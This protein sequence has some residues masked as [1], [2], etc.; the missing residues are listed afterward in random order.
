MKI[1]WTEETRNKN[2]NPSLWSLFRFRLW[3]TW[4]SREL[5]LNT[6]VFILFVK[7]LIISNL[8]FWNYFP[9]ENP[10]KI[11]LAA[12]IFSWLRSFLVKSIVDLISRTVSISWFT[13]NP[14]ASLVNYRNTV[15]Y[16]T[17][18]H[19]HARIKRGVRGVP[20]SPT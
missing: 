10:Q 17:L 18:E 9:R 2:T 15:C 19:V 20:T 13:P 16:V 1:I 7:D 8:K 5:S 11:S 14:C 4:L 12:V 6:N 3:V